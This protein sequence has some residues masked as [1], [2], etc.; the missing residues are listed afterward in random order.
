M[1]PTDVPPRAWSGRVDGDG[2]EHLRWHSAVSDQDTGAVVIGF[3][4]DAGVRRNGGRPGAAAGPAALRAALGPLALQR[5]LPLSDAGDVVVTG[6]DLEA[7]QARLGAA[8]ST[9]IDSGRLPV[10]LGG[11]H[12]VAYGTHLGIAHPTGT[13]VGILNLDAHFDLRKQDRPS[14]GTPFRQI[15]DAHPDVR[16][17]V[18]GISE[19]SNTRALFDAAGALGVPYLLDEDCAQPAVD[20][21]VD[22][23]LADVD[24]VHLTIDLDVLP[25]AVAPGVSAPAAYGVPLPIIARVCRTV[26]AS[27]RLVAVDVAELNPA[28]D[29]DARTARAAAR[30]IHIVVTAHRPARRTADP[31]A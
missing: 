23:F 12:E 4:S 11:G 17:A 13:R 5:P 3:A 27:G 29:V 25:A 7:G 14:S 18:I 10:V 30:L 28:L 19:P 15:L 6:D 24:V 9:A 20:A 31:R 26:A 22:R 2:P 21:F 1:I 8:V 16:Y